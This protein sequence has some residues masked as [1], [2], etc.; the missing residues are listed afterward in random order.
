M[1]LNETIKIEGKRESLLLSEGSSV[2]ASQ[3]R[4]Q[5]YSRPLSLLNLIVCLENLY[6]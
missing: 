3:E 2:Y 1:A 4:R 5:G 6:P